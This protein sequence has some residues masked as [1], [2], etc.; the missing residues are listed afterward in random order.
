MVL[1]F[2]LLLVG[3]LLG[4]LI[5]DVP[6]FTLDRQLRPFEI[7]T[8]LFVTLFGFWFQRYTLK[9][10][11]KY[12]S[13]KE[14]MK[15]VSSDCLECLN[16]IHDIIKYGLNGSLDD[17]KKKMIHQKLKD[18][19]FHIEF[20]SELNSND[21]L[22]EQ[23]FEYK[24]DIVNEDFSTSDFTVDQRYYRDVSNST[25]LIRKIIRQCVYGQL[26]TSR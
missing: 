18:L 12:D 2:I 5:E 4:V 7:F 15:D 14:V 16:D 24:N 6:Y 3:F 23:Y 20:L 22:K 17:N 25:N 1:G 13:V 26:S 21:S 9:N 8:F 19:S 10:T 11:R